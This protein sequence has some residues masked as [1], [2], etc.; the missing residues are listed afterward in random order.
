MFNRVYVEITDRCNLNCA[1]C[2]GT[3][4]PLGEMSP[5]AFAVVAEKLRPVTGYLYFHVM[6]EPLLHPQLEALL[7]IAGEKGFKV[8]L[9]TNGTLLRKRE[10]VLLAAGSL[11]K[12]SVSLHSFEGNG[13]PDMEAYLTQ[14][15]ESCRALAGRGVICVLRL[16]NE[17]GLEQRNGEIED[18]L[19]R[20]TGTCPADWPQTRQ[21][22]WRLA[23]GVFLERACRFDWPDA[24]AEE[25]GTQFCYGLRSQMGVLWDGTVVPCCLDHEGDLALGNLLEQD[26]E[27]ILE[28]PR[29]KAIYEGFSRRQPS[30]ELCRRCGYASRF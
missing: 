29:A 21:D 20:K 6:G 2:P 23:P 9:T 14:V 5:Q 8:C 4:R 26:L 19:A 7:T 12:V 18:F 3:R 1:F 27:E 16:W 30:E 10:G 25:T 13:A 28:S 11:H 22:T 24:G 17:G 15:W